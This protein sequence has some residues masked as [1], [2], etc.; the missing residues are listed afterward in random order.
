MKKNGLVLIALIAALLPLQLSLAAY[1]IYVSPKGDD[2]NLGTKSK[3]LATLQET[4]D[5]VRTLPADIK[6]GGVT[7]HLKKA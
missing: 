5:V 7:I 3:P 6:A 1:N 4:R 2:L